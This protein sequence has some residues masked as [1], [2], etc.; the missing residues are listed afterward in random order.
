M[1]TTTPQWSARFVRRLLS[2]TSAVPE[3]ALSSPPP[4]PPGMRPSSVPPQ[5]APGWRLPVAAGLSACVGGWSLH[6]GVERAQREQTGHCGRPHCLGLAPRAPELVSRLQSHRFRMPLDTPRLGETPLH[7][8]PMLHPHVHVGAR[9]LRARL[10]PG[11]GRAGHS[12]PIILTLHPHITLILHPR[13]SPSPFTLTPTLT[14]TL[15][16]P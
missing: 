14:L 5:G 7:A 10:G 4:L 13:P 3:R 9:L 11:V 16:S 15:T 8:T 6:Q 1:P 12:C 2:E